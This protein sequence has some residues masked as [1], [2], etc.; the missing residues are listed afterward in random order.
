MI[1]FSGGLNPDAGAAMFNG[2]NSSCTAT[3]DFTTNYPKT[4][5]TATTRLCHFDADCAGLSAFG[6]DLNKCCTSTLAPGL[7][8]CAAALFGF[9]CN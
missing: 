4:P 2:G 1:V 5:T 6:T 8:F 3:C 7:H 9:T